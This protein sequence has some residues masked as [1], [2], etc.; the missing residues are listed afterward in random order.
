MPF[1]F[2]SADGATRG[3][4]PFDFSGKPKGQEITGERYTYYPRETQGVHHLESH[5]LERVN[6]L[7]VYLCPT[8]WVK[9]LSEY[10][11]K[12]AAFLYA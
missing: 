8:L 6:P 7:L 1:W 5:A 4:C 2:C 3:V 12:K 11:G 10:R 9:L